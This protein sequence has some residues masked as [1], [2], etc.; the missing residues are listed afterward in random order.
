MMSGWW[1]QAIKERDVEDLV[2]FDDRYKG[3]D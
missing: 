2:T 1:R 3:F